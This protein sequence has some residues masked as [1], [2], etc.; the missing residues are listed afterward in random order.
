MA[1]FVSNAF[2]SDVVAPRGNPITVQTSTPVPFSETKDAISKGATEVDMVINIGAL[3]DGDDE[4]VEADIRAAVAPPVEKPVDVL[5]KSA[6][7]DTA[8]RH[9]R[10]F[11]SSVKRHI[12]VKASGGIRTKADVDSMIA[13]GASR[14]GASAGVSIVSGGRYFICVLLLFVFAYNFLCINK[15]RGWRKLSASAL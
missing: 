11:S 3:K 4:A 6:P 9:A 1:S 12:G 14:I 13:A 2:V 15:E 7:A 5:T 8:K 10:S